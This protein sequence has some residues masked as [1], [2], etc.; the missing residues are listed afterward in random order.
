MVVDGRIGFVGGINLSRTYE[1]PPSAG[2]PANGDTRSRLLARYRC[3]DPGSRCRRTP[4]T[5]LRHMET[6]ERRS[7]AR[8]PITFRRCRDRA[9]RPSASSAALQATTAALLHLARGSDPRGRQPHLAV[10]RLFRAAAPGARG[11]GKGGA[12]GH[13]SA[14]GRAEPHRRGE[15]RCMPVGPPTAICWKP[16]RASSRCRTPCCT[17]SLQSSM[18]YGPPSAR[19]TSIAAAS[20]STT[21]S[22]PSS[23]APIPLR[24]SRRCCNATWRPPLPVALQGWQSGDR[25]ASG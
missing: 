17:R 14:V 13:R 4:A 5:V 24:R 20:C 23:L 2:I 21:R 6:A 3:G 22:T 10:H 18:A 19:P 7:G 9:C 15:T 8:Q 11:S 12:A 25:S 16:A 1:N